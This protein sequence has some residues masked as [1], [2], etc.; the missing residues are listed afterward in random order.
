MTQAFDEAIVA[1]S[2]DA[3]DETKRGTV[4]RFI[5]HLAEIDGGL[6]S[7]ASIA[8]SRLSEALAICCVMAITALGATSS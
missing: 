5:F 7:A 1:M 6:D 8:R 2:V 3:E 4:A